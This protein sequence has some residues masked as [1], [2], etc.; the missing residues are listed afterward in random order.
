MGDGSDSKIKI[1]REKLDKGYL[2]FVSLQA[3]IRKSYD[4]LSMI[5]YKLTASSF[6]E[7]VF[8]NLLFM[9][10]YFFNMPTNRVVRFMRNFIFVYGMTNGIRQEKT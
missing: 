9:C 4:M 8:L 10:T 5:S 6:F 7:F 2:C 1:I 3:K